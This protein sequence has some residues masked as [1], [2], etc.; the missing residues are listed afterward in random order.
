MNWIKE[1]RFRSLILLVLIIPQVTYAAW[2]NPLSWFNNWSFRKTDTTTQILEKRIAELENRLASTSTSTEVTTAT[3]TATTK[4]IRRMTREEYQAE[5]GV[6][7]DV[8]PT[9]SKPVTANPKPSTETQIVNS[10][11]PEE[12]FSAATASGLL[13]QAKSY[14]DLADFADGVIDYIDVAISELNTLIAQ[15]EGYVAVLG[16]E[17]SEISRSLI[18]VYQEDITKTNVYKKYLADI[19]D[20]ALRTVLFYKNSAFEKAGKFISKQEFVAI[21][22]S[23]IKDPNWSLTRENILKA[24]EGYKSYRQYKDNLYT[25]WDAEMR[26][27]LQQ[28]NSAPSAP[29]VP[30]YQPQPTPQIQTPTYISPQTTHCTISGD[31]GVGL[32]AYVNCT[33][34]SY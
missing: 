13:A 25:K 29:S 12:N 8:K 5:F 19:R 7:P 18:A 28:A 24:Y 33:T 15:N 16:Y 32:Q 34:S 11:A 10:P 3:S 21:T 20:Y 26:A 14:Q 1:N 2:W 27:I 9:V 30:A 6:S 22:E 17:K 4:P 23:L 31:G